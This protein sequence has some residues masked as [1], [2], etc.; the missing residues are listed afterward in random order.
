MVKNFADKTNLKN[1]C[2]VKYK[3]QKYIITKLNINSSLKKLDEH[4]ISKKTIQSI[5]NIF[6]KYE[7]YF[8]NIN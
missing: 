4:K 2:I 8:E 5:N 3:E 1:I 6:K 7:F